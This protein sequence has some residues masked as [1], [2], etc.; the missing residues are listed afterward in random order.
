MQTQLGVHAQPV[1]VAVGALPDESTPKSLAKTSTQELSL[2][3][4][5]KIQAL[6][7]ALV[8][9]RFTNFS[10]PF[11]LTLVVVVFTVATMSGIFVYNIGA[12]TEVCVTTVQFPQVFD[13]YHRQRQ[14]I[15][16]T[17]MPIPIE[18][19]PSNVK[20]EVSVSLCIER[21]QVSVPGD[22]GWSYWWM[23]ADPQAEGYR[24]PPPVMNECYPPPGFMQGFET[25][26][27]YEGTD[28]CG[29]AC[30]KERYAPTTANKWTGEKDEVYIIG[31]CDPDAYQITTSWNDGNKRVQGAKAIESLGNEFVAVQCPAL[32]GG[33]GSVSWSIVYQQ[34]T[35][36]CTTTKP[37]F[38]AAAGTAL[39]YSSYIEMLVTLL[40]VVGFT[41]TGV[42]HMKKKVEMSVLL[43]EDAS[44][45][46][47]DPE[48]KEE[49][50]RLKE[51][52]AL[53]MRE[54][55]QVRCTCT[56]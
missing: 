11:L 14:W 17:K 26:E 51:Q 24:L 25:A 19:L 40:C 54:S 32:Q 43:S 56:H 34:R 48:L 21:A 42:M 13:S 38:V 7:V 33:G 49:L 50:D 22:L 8:N 27:R 37:T 46:T 47:R 6:V 4:M 55:V 53:L 9:P 30:H 41:K 15:K 12:G 5:Q 28:D 3:F 35:T 2:T 23:N 20:V 16:R 36:T 45:M 44:V 31:L 1:S 29:T 52:V 39:A 18:G 10:R